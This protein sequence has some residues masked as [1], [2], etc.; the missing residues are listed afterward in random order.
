[1]ISSDCSRA[2]ATPGRLLECDALRRTLRASDA[3]GNP[4]GDFSA[5]GV[6]SGALCLLSGSPGSSGTGGLS[7]KLHAHLATELIETHRGINHIAKKQSCPQSYQHLGCLVHG[8]NY[9]TPSHQ[10][11]ASFLAE[12]VPTEDH[13]TLTRL[14][15]VIKNINLTITLD[16]D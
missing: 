6:A 9:R 5:G 14:I 2:T 15:K 8:L 4:G 7:P 11:I 16:F 10:L 3:I 13:L 12:V 1:M